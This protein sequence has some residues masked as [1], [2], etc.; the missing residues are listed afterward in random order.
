MGHHAAI[1]IRVKVKKDAPDYIRQFMDTFFF[2]TDIDKAIADLEHHPLT[3]LCALKYYPPGDGSLTGMIA[4]VSVYHKSWCWRV[5]EEYEDYTLYESKASCN[6]RSVDEDLLVLLL[7]GLSSFLVVSDGD[8]LARVVYESA[9]SERVVLFDKATDACITANGY[10]HKWTDDEEM[11][12]GSHPREQGQ[13]ESE[14]L[15]DKEGANRFTRLM[16]IEH[17]FY[18]PWNIADVFVRN[19]AN[20]GKWAIERAENRGFGF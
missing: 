8:I 10:L 18:P 9:S 6:H 5:K 20:D 19:T 16:P 1:N 11:G 14:P 2:E 17:D 4:Q 7:S 15:C 12:D 13:Y 3:P